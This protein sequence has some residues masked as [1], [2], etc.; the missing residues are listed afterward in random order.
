MEKA[1]EGTRKE[2]RRKVSPEN[3]KKKGYLSRQISFRFASSEQISVSAPS[4]KSE[5]GIPFRKSSRKRLQARWNGGSKSLPRQSVKLVP[6]SFNLQVFALGSV[7]F[8]LYRV[9]SSLSSIKGEAVHLIPFHLS[10]ESHHTYQ[11]LLSDLFP[12]SFLLLFRLL[13]SS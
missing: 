2:R 4:R 1:W 8:A 3:L 9:I 11:K 6:G 10:S 13:H 5:E 12:L 7:P